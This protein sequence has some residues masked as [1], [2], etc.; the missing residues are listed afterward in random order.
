MKIKYLTILMIIAIAPV[1]GCTREVSPSTPPNPVNSEYEQSRTLSISGTGSVKVFPNLIT[2]SAQVTAVDK[3]VLAARE[4]AAETMTAILRTLE[5]NQIT[6]DEVST[7]SFRISER[8]I[9]RDGE[10]I[11]IGFEVTNSIQISIT[12]LDSAPRILDDMITAG[13]DAIRIN[14]FELTIADKEKYLEV[15]RNKAVTNAKEQAEMLSTATGVKL[16]HILSINTQANIPT[17]YPRFGVASM[18]A[19]PLGDTS[20]PIAFGTQNIAATVMIVWKIE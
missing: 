12:E 17:Q 10:S 8:T 16:G 15:A 3:S 5:K 1:I 6:E 9:W 4:E 7:T 20:T 2:I 18:E 13:K 14:S 11:R 19:A